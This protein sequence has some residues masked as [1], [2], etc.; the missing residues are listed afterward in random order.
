MGACAC[1]CTNHRHAH[2]Y[3]QNMFLAVAVWQMVRIL[4]GSGATSCICDPS[5][6]LGWN[7]IPSF[8]MARLGSCIPTVSP[9]WVKLKADRLGAKDPWCGEAI[10]LSSWLWNQYQRDAG[11]GAGNSLT[12]LCPFLAMAV[13]PEVF[14]A[15]F[16]GLGVPTSTVTL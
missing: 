16:L 8:N 9:S 1:M 15:V 3:I 2:S 12:A 7:S 11:P 5:K 14:P 10:P 4:G 13:S 6:T